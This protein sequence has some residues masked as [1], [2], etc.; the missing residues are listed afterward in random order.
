MLWIIIGTLLFNCLSLFSFPF[1]VI[2][3][4]GDGQFSSSRGS[5]AAPVKKIYRHLQQ[6]SRML[7]RF[8]PDHDLAGQKRM[9]VLKVN[10][11]YS[12]LSP[13]CRTIR[14]VN[15]IFGFQNDRNHPD[16]PITVLPAD[17]RMQGIPHPNHLLGNIWALKQCPHCNVTY[18]RDVNA[19]R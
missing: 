3:A 18:Q 9:I 7:G 15:N 11:H 8:P 13:S 4:F 12:S 17:E 6:V 19:C 5:P 2:I 10:E 14:L 16:L 1:R